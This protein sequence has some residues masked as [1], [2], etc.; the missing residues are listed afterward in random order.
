M[1][2]NILMKSALFTTHADL[3]LPLWEPNVD[4]IY[5]YNDELP[6]T[7]PQFDKVYFRDP[8][9]DPTDPTLDSRLEEIT[10]QFFHNN[11][12]CYS[13]DHVHTVEDF[14]IEDKWRQFYQFGKDFMPETWLAREREFVPGEMVVKKRI[15]CRCRDV[16]F[17]IPEGA[18]LDSYIVQHRVNIVQ[19][20]RVFYLNGQVFRTAE[21]RTSKTETQGVKVI[22]EIQLT[23]E[24][25]DFV[26][27]AM[28]KFPELDFVGVDLA[29]LDD[30]SLAIIEI[31]RSPQFKGFYKVTGIN[32]AELVF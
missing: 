10:T 16:H 7:F 19:E 17:E 26:K 13:I 3:A 11:S 29:V 20:M 9:N 23:D 25:M 32:L 8:F 30:G 12:D 31:N 18:N 22:G 24:Q 1:C 5:Y 4:T 14:Y 6:A 2:Y 21:T 27:R 28:A 15:S